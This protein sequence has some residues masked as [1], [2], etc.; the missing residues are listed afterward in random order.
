LVKFSPLWYIVP[1]KFWQSILSKRHIVETTDCQNNM[2]CQYDICIVETT[3]VLLKRHMY[4]RNDICIVETTYV[5]S[6]RHMYC[7]N[8]ICILNNAFLSSNAFCLT[9]LL[10]FLTN[11]TRILPNEDWVAGLSGRVTIRAAL[12]G[13]NWAHFIVDHFG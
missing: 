6:K 12:F 1:R 9:Y 13:T 3:Y 5:L 4:C 10:L 2:Y 7:Q 11:L 8:D